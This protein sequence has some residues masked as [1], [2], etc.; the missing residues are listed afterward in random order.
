MVDGLAASEFSI[1]ATA[2]TY[3]H[4]ALRV[5]DSTVV[6]AAVRN[7]GTLN[8][9][10]NVRFDVVRL[11]G[12][13]DMLR[14]QSLTVAQGRSRR[15]RLIGSPT[16]RVPSGSRWCCRKATG[17]RSVVEVRPPEN[18]ALGERVLDPSTRCSGA[19]WGCSSCLWRASSFAVL[20]RR[21][22]EQGAKESIDWNA[23]DALDDERGTRTKRRRTAMRNPAPRPQHALRRGQPP[24]THPQPSRRT[25][26]GI[27]GMDARG[28]WRLVVQDPPTAPVVPRRTRRKQA[29]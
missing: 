17:Q 18:T 27:H 10:V 3:Q 25:S 9:A 19:L 7:T 29:A 2:V 11:D 15:W 21:T 6:E 20:T 1:D 5:G 26:P 8:G 24:R 14:E 4:L 13:R 12:S 23:F 22:T 28:R 16:A